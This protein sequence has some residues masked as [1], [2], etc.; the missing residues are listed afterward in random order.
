MAAVEEAIPVSPVIRTGL[1]AV[2][3]VSGAGTDAVNGDY[4]EIPVGHDDVQGGAVGDRRRARMAKGMS[5][6][7]G[8]GAEAFK[9]SDEDESD[10]SDDEPASKGYMKINPDGTPWLNV[11]GGNVQISYH[12]AYGEDVVI[13]KPDA[14]IRTTSTSSVSS[15]KAI[16]PGMGFWMIAF[17]PYQALKTGVAR[18]FSTSMRDF[19]ICRALPGT[20]LPES[21]WTASDREIELEGSKPYPHITHL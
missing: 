3:R 4:A 5:K 16:E 6:G 18:T 20:G 9:G 2:L 11:C 19:Y 13:K 21:G 17:P 14:R 1:K 12:T 15:C 10:D 7:L 8:N